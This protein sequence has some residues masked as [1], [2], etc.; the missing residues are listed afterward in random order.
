MVLSKV[1]L[2]Q[3]QKNYSDQL[4]KTLKNE[5]YFSSFK[6]IIW[7][8]NPADIQLISKPNKKVCFVLCVTDIHL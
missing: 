1:K 2:S 5:K 3:T 8:A 6:D 4:F 7:G